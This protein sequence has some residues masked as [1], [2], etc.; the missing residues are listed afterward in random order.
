MSHP[1]SH[2]SRFYTIAL[3]TFIGFLFQPLSQAERGSSTVSLK[4]LHRLN[5]LVKQR[6]MEGRVQFLHDFDK[7][8]QK[9]E[10]EK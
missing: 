5:E 8:S 7:S 9:N 2:P 6:G 1:V 4:D 3:N 10:E